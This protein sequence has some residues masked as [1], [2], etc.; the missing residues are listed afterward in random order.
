MRLQLALDML[1]TDAALE[2]AMAA[3]PWVDI[4]EIGTPL[5]K[6][7]GLNVL[8]KLRE[9]FP[10]KRLLVDL[11]TMDVGRYEADFAF[12]AGADMVTVLGVADDATLAGTIASAQAHGKTAVVDLINVNDKATRARQAQAMGADYVA[13]HSGIDQQHQGHAPLADLG[14]VRQAVSIG[15]SVAGGIGLDNLDP[16]LALNPD[17]VVVGGAI[18]SAQDP[19]EAARLIKARMDA[20][21]V[22]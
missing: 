21:E 18:T 16:I 22:R 14:S 3:A 8:Y 15:V 7:E 10:D 12:G 13:V 5:I 20:A 11:K 2:V 19:M 1:H 9:R 6:H 4:I 17:I